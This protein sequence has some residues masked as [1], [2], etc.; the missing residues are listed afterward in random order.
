MRIA[1]FGEC[2]QA[3]RYNGLDPVGSAFYAFVLWMR[4]TTI[5]EE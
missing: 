5:T 4:E 2:Y 3:L 1:T